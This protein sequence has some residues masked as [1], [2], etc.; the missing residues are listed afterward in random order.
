LA[1]RGASRAAAAR[2][3]VAGAAAVTG[4]AKGVVAA[5]GSGT[6]LA[7]PPAAGLDTL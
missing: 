5:A 3:A 1:W 6:F 7:G 4:A 2:A